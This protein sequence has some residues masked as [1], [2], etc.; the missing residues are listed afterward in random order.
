MLLVT[1]TQV[2]TKNLVTKS[3]FLVVSSEILHKVYKYKVENIEN[4]WGF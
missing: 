3:T 2:V 1:K 4:G